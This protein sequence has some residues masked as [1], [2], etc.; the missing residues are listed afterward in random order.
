MKER[1][2]RHDDGEGVLMRGGS[3]LCWI[4]EGMAVGMIERERCDGHHGG[5]DWECDT[6]AGQDWI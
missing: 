6:A 2:Y 5:D 3:L 4:V 1:G